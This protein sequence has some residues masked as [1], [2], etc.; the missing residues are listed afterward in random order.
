MKVQTHFAGDLF[1]GVRDPKRMAIRVSCDCTI[2]VSPHCDLMGLN[3]PY[4]AIL[5]EYPE[6]NPLRLEY[7]S[8]S[9]LA[10]P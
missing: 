5:V 3:L 10:D 4:D 2:G 8:D 9:L 6:R 7:D 1:Q